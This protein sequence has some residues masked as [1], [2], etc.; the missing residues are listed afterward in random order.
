MKC[1]H[2]TEKT[3]NQLGI[4]KDSKIDSHSYSF[5]VSIPNIFRVFPYGKTRIGKEWGKGR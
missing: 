2:S 3:A 5:Q 1:D 4:N